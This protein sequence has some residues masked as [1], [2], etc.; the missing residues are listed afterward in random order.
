MLK[1]ASNKEML[2]ELHYLS[3]PR[4]KFVII[5]LTELNHNRILDNCIFGNRSWPN[6]DESFNN[7][8]YVL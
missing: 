7:T 5:L 6:D 1:F 4:V 8:E 3:Q 2:C